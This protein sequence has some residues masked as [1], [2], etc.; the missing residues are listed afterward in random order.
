MGADGGV[1]ATP[2]VQGL[3]PAWSYCFGGGAVMP[4]ANDEER[5]EG[6]RGLCSPNPSVLERKSD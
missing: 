3:E 5:S 6:S 4:N 1:L 2:G